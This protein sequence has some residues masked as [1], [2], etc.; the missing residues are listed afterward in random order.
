VPVP[1][2]VVCHLGGGCSITAVRDGRS[3]ETTMGF[4]PLEGVPMATRSGSIDVEIVL[5][6]LRTGKLGLDEVERALESESGLLGLS[7]TT[8]RVEE[9]EQSTE[10][11][12][13]LALRVFGHRVAAAVAST[14]V[15]LGGIDAIVFT[16]GIGEGSSRVRA[17]VCARLAFLGV[18]LD[19]DAN[20]AA[21]PD[22]DVAAAQSPIRVVVI[23]AREDVVAARAV[24]AL[25]AL[26]AQAT[27]E[28]F[29]VVTRR[30]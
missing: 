9:L 20:A 4:S 18:E 6:L 25:L 1:R 7:G 14:A 27:I 24:R 16:A 12:A 28:P 29:R 22:I 8:S 10:P 23:H 26:P 17:D 11:S 5:H 2:L 30:T 13:Q 15:S 21:R 19:A 3:V